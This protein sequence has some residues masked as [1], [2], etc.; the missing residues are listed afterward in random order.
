MSLFKLQKVST[1]MVTDSSGNKLSSLLA[2]IAQQI[3][4]G[5]GGG[6]SVTVSSLS[7]LQSLY[8][9]GLSVPVWVTSENAWYYWDGGTTPP[10]DTTP[11]DNV[12][13]LQ[14]TNVTDTSLTLSWTAVSDAASYE[15]YRGTTL[16]S[17]VTGTTYNVSG[18]TAST[19]YTFTVKAKDAAGNVASGTSVNSTT[20]A[21]TPTVSYEYLIPTSA[22]KAVSGSGN[23]KGDEFMMKVSKQLNSVGAY[24][25]PTSYEVWSVNSADHTLS[26]QLSTG[27]FSGNADG[28]GYKVANLSTPITL[29]ANG[30]YALIVSYG[31]SATARYVDAVAN[32]TYKTDDA[33]LV[34]TVRTFNA[35]PAVGN[36]AGGTF[37]Y[38]FKLGLL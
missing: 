35:Q 30:Y 24:G 17:T 26:A 12:T 20:N 38:D 34:S 1:D 29:N 2:D 25:S 18:L 36:T 37:I 8:P 13:N 10:S 3:G 5:G 28:E 32:P 9:N 33:V 6:G 21:P 22:T 7:S 23:Y 31:A 16:L 19:S 14:A 27:S 15:V 4:E 11:P